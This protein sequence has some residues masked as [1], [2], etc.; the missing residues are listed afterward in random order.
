MP[1]TAR[2][3]TPVCEQCGAPLQSLAPEAGCLNCLLGTGIEGDRE[4][5]PP[6]PNESGAR[7][8]EHYE[9]LT[10]PDGSLWELGRG[11]MGIT[12]K[13]RD[14]NLDTIVALKVINA[15]FSAR[16]EARR[17]LLHE[18]R[19][20]APLRHQNVAS[21]FHFGTT[22]EAAPVQ[23]ATNA[24]ENHRGDCFYAMEFVDGESLEARVRRTGPL[25][26]SLAL[27]IAL[28]VARALVAAEKR[29]LV[30]RDLRPSNIML[31]ADGETIPARDL[32]GSSARVRVK[33]IDFGL[34]K[35]AGD[36]TDSSVPGCF[37]GTPALSNPEQRASGGIDSRSDIYSLGVTLWYA[38]TGRLPGDRS[39]E[40]PL[41]M[42]QLAKHDVPAP[43][44]ALLKSMLA[45]A[46]ENRPRSA[47][48]LTEALQRCLDSVNNA[49][50][51][52]RGRCA[53]LGRGC[54]F[55]FGGGFDR[56]GHLLHPCV[57]VLGGEIN[58]R[59]ALSK[60]GRAIRPMPFLPKA[61]RTTSFPV[62]SRSV[63]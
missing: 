27:E 41:P 37:L 61:C 35:L 60:P 33:V 58:R 24:E 40:T 3:E 16:P 22:D 34:A 9:I 30:H 26:A 12:Y 56:R 31:A 52:P 11:A 5:A 42:D 59:A 51:F 48:E 50:W 36:G 57:F 44:I 21:V 23:E 55:G 43:V 6:S 19:T 49:T 2:N 7:V 45:P 54:R 15:R 53:A 4:E 46:P 32:L 14:V 10:L 1:T 20:A 18:A 25:G 39:A 47:V 63:T 62:W 29:G 17:R 28:Q 38:L 13:A 8:Y